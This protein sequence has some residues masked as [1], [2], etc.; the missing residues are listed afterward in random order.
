MKKLKVKEF[1]IGERL[2][3]IEFIKKLIDKDNSSAEYVSL[4]NPRQD[5]KKE[6]Y[7]LWAKRID[8]III[9]LLVALLVLIYCI[10]DEGDKGL[11]HSGNMLDRPETA[12]DVKLY[13]SDTDKT[14][15]EELSLEVNS[16]EFTEDELKKIDE[17]VSSYVEETLKGENTSLDHIRSSI[18]LVSAIPGVKVVLKWETD[19]KYISSAGEIIRDNIP[20]A[21]TQT[22]VML[23]AKWKNFKQVY[24]YN[25]F[26]D[27]PEFTDTEIAIKNARSAISEAVSGQATS[28]QISLPAQYRYREEKEKKNFLPVWLICIVIFL[29]PLIWQETKKKKIQAREAQLVLDHPG[30]INK[31]MLLLG[32]GLSFRKVVERLCEEYERGRAEGAGIHFVYEELCVCQ[33]KMKDGVSDVQAIESFGKRLSCMPYMRFA[34]VITQNI[35]KG[36]DGILVLLEKE[37][38]DSLVERKQTALRLGEVAGTKLLF[39]MMIMLGLV[40]AIIMV[41]AFMSM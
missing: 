14:W 4:I 15:E 25:L 17:R 22:D 1:S 11:L 3:S 38:A 23:E 12:E 5:N 33:Q 27:P 16:R 30:F 29:L 36:S 2:L 24:H 26:I 7:K 9:L 35:K 10:T 6:L 20:E 41:P 18:V 21:G 28:K 31:V 39:P 13:V 19:E 32:A 34:S 40:M 8:L 37:A